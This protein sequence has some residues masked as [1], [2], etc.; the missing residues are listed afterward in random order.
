ME[1]RYQVRLQELMED[2]VVKPEQCA[3]MLAR[4]EQFVEP[5]AACLVRS[6]HECSPAVRRRF[7]VAGETQERGVD[8]LPSRAGPTDHAE[9]HRPEPLGHGR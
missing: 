5:F 1:R 6:K 8:R 9:V 4:L 3:G 7:G 2:A